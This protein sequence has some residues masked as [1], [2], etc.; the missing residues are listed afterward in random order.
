MS[1][2]WEMHI[3][4]SYRRSDELK[5]DHISR[6][7]NKDSTTNLTL[8]AENP[9]TCS[10]MHFRLPACALASLPVQPWPFSPYPSSRPHL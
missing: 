9:P 7:H 8:I 1:D 5:F 2:G 4:N 6:Q 10:S 3:L